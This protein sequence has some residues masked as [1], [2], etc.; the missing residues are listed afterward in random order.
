MELKR[1]YQNQRQGQRRYC[2]SVKWMCGHF[3]KKISLAT[4]ACTQALS[5]VQCL[6]LSVMHSK[7]FYLSQSP[8]LHVF[9]LVLVCIT[10]YCSFIFLVHDSFTASRI[11]KATESLTGLTLPIFYL[12]L[13]LC[14]FLFFFSF[15]KI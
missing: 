13:S 14:V 3:R 1:S 9:A 7:G 11:S 6:Y 2:K 12:S 15:S 10:V 8:P 5:N 4:C